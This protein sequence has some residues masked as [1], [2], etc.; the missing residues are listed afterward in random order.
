MEPYEFMDFKRYKYISKDLE[1]DRL[2]TCDLGIWFRL[3]RV[4]SSY[5]FQRKM[6]SLFQE[7]DFLDLKVLRR[8]GDTLYRATLN[9]RNF[10]KFLDSENLGIFGDDYSIIVNGFHLNEDEGG[11]IDATGP[12]TPLKAVEKHRKVD[13]NVLQ[14][15]LKKSAEKN[16]P[17]A[18]GV[19][20][21]NLLCDFTEVDNIMTHFNISMEDVD[22]LIK[23]TPAIPSLLVVLKKNVEDWLKE[24]D[25]RRDPYLLYQPAPQS[26]RMGRTQIWAHVV[27]EDNQFDRRVT[28]EGIYKRVSNAEITHT[29]SY[30]GEILSTPQPLMWK[31]SDLPNGDLVVNMRLQ[32]EMNF[33][34]IKGEA[35]KV[36]YAKQ[37]RQCS[38]CFSFRHK[39]FECDRWETDSRTLLFDYYKKWQRQVDF[40]EFQ[41]LRAEMEGADTKTPIQPK[42]LSKADDDETDPEIVAV[43]DKDNLNPE[44]L[45]KE[46]G[47]KYNTKGTGLR[48]PDTDQKTDNNKKLGSVQRQLFADNNSNTN[49]GEKEDPEEG[50]QVAVHKEGE[51]A[52]A[53]DEEGLEV[54]Q[55]EGIE[56]SAVDNEVK[57]KLATS[58]SRPRSEE[59]KLKDNMVPDEDTVKPASLTKSAPLGQEP[60]KTLASGDDGNKKLKQSEEYEETSE[61]DKKRKHENSSTKLTPENKKSNV[62][63]K[64]ELLKELKK[65]EK[66]AKQKDLT[67]V[68]KK[69]LKSR[70]EGFLNSNNDKMKRLQGEDRLELEQLEAKLRSLLEKK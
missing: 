38:H 15:D 51:Q 41:P 65:M 6:T 55:K 27:L 4:S 3:E 67:E 24:A 9:K 11:D 35:Y 42:R 18:R 16:G 62:N 37:E 69:V 33:I 68:K 12:E 43:P 61:K 30:N 13:D 36:S 58:E 31:G 19:L 39:N 57:P 5:G 44:P 50:V 7:V 32:T 1:D 46:F 17:M 53:Y 49:E 26:E 8:G 59:E 21:Y 52:A 29:L 47:D 22:A 23:P 20:T 40:K 14:I 48:S 64:P 25:V 63:E 45:L 10:T 2:I 34:I 66:E 56:M 60:V 54:A 70:L 28:I